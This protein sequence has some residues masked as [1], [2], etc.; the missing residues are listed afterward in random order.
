MTET[1]PGNSAGVLANTTLTERELIIHMLQHIE[2]LYEQ[3][4]EVHGAVM[5]I[6]GQLSVF[7][8]LLAKYAPGGK[9]DFIGANQMRKEARRR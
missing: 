2:D 3:M 7:A 1:F 9:L 4:S 6:D 8:P 5:R